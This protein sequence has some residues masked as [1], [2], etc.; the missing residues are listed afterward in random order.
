MIASI[1]YVARRRFE[2]FYQTKIAKDARAISSVTGCKKPCRY[3]KY[4][5]SGEQTKIPLNDTYTDGFMLWSM[6]DEKMVNEL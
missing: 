1:V 5:L 6:A 3:R 2:W 4:I